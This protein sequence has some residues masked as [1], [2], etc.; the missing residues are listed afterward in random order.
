MQQRALLRQVDHRAGPE[1]AA[2]QPAEHPVVAD[3]RFHDDPQPARVVEDELQDR[4]E[5]RAGETPLGG[6]RRSDEQVD[7]HVAGEHLVAPADRIGPGLVRLH[8]RDRYAVAVCQ[9]RVVGGK[10]VQVRVDLAYALAAGLAHPPEPGAFGSDPAVQQVG[11]LVRAHRADG[12]HPET[13]HV[14]AVVR[15]VSAHPTPR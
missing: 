15:F 2:P 9:V 1:P 13:G 7:A 10:R 11:V 6:H 12:D 5:Q 14:A 8:Q 4:A 3:V